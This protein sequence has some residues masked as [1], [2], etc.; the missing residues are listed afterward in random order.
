MS[1]PPPALASSTAAQQLAAWRPL[2]RS[3]IPGPACVSRS[4]S[5]LARGA[6]AR[7][8]LRPRLV[9]AQSHPPPPLPAV[10][11]DAETGLALLLVVIAAV[12][13]ISFRFSLAFV[14]VLASGKPLVEQEAEEVPGTLSSLKLSFLEISDLTSQLKNIRKRITISRFGK[15]ASTKLQYPV[16]SVWQISDDVSVP[17]MADFIG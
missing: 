3:L 8:S 15:E 13:R 4:S 16:A 14:V 10:R 9:A 17:Q 7:Y 12:L 5:I 6:S 1:S 2:R 11:R